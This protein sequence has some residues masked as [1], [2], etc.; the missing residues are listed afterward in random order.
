[1]YVLT[2]AL[3]NKHGYSYKNL[4][5]EWGSLLV[6]DVEDKVTNAHV[7]GAHQNR[8]FLLLQLPSQ[9]IDPR[10]NHYNTYYCQYHV[11]KSK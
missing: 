11:P 2:K 3:L 5:W 1:M 8:Y 9:H 10:P 7:T 6:R 4:D